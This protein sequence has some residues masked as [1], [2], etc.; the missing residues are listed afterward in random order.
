MTAIPPLLMLAS[1]RKPRARKAPTIRP[2]ESRLQCDVAEVL[3]RH[4]LP[5][6]LWWHTPNGE[7]RDVRTAAGLK[8]HGSPIPAFQTLCW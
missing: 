1:G 4:A 7:L 5:D 2:R 3:R 8:A 6:W